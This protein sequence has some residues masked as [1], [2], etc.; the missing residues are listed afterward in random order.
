MNI[1]A[2]EDILALLGTT[3]IP[4]EEQIPIKTALESAINMMGDS[5]DKRTLA[6]AKASL[7]SNYASIERLLKTTIFK[8]KLKNQAVID[9]VTE[10][11]SRNGL[12]TAAKT[13]TAQAKRHDQSLGIFFIDLTGFKPI[14]DSMGHEEGD[15]ALK[16]FGKALANG[17]RRED[18]V[19]RPGGD[20]FVIVMINDDPEHDF[21]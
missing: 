5:P 12:N 11:L 9:S 14:N 15:I 17:V 13:Y 6:F 10:L 21:P 3:E 20:E 1:L 18:L 4:E 19:S 8:E 2:Y 16:K 7:S